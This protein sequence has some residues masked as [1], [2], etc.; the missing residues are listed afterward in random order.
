MNTE[1]S[2][3]AF[4]KEQTLETSPKTSGI[5]VVCGYLLLPREGLNR[6]LCP[7]LITRLR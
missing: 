3:R 7:F 6:Q 4:A 1:S 2:L 5:V